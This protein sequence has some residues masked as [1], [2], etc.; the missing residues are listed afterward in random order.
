VDP[1]ATGL[2][3][4]RLEQP[5]MLKTKAIVEITSAIEMQDSTMA[6]TATSL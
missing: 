1:Q 4:F 2:K 3:L 5:G 6:A